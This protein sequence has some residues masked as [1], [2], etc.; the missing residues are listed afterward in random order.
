MKTV[1]LDCGTIGQ[2]QVK[3]KFIQILEEQEI[4]KG[5][6]EGIDY[7]YNRGWK[8]IGVSNSQVEAGGESLEDAI[9]RH[10][11]IL[12]LL[13]KISAI[14]FCAD[15]QGLSCWRVIHNDA[16]LISNHSRVEEFLVHEQYKF[17]MPGAGMLYLA[18]I[19]FGIDLEESWMVGDASEHELAATNAKLK[20]FM[21]S[22]IWVNRFKPGMYEVRSVSFQQVQFLE[23]LR[24]SY[25][26]N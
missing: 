18:S 25:D 22:D 17:R 13:P 26:N 10:Q 8:I 2:P 12:A 5:V 21:P 14:Y 15:I 19:D 4:I 16:H 24:E 7:Y 9:A 23:N 20:G 3:N 1:F 11:S 6:S